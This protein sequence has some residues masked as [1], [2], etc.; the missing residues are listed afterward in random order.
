MFFLSLA[1]MVSQSRILLAEFPFSRRKWIHKKLHVIFSSKP[2]LGC[3]SSWE[4][5]AVI[6]IYIVAAILSETVFLVDESSW[7]SIKSKS[8]LNA[9]VT[10]MCQEA[11]S[12]FSNFCLAL[13]YHSKQLNWKRPETMKRA[14]HELF[15]IQKNRY[16]QLG[17]K[18][19]CLHNKKEKIDHGI[20][21]CFQVGVE[22]NSVE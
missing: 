7:S 21:I 11:S 5:A 20:F 22:G 8:P 16:L 9:I 13:Q 12:D 1:P 19:C 4:R 3:G 6:L 15:F 2:V 10:P 17:V 14:R 18:T